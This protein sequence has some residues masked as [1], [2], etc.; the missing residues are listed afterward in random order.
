MCATAIEPL[1]YV[2][3]VKR[4]IDFEALAVLPLPGEKCEQWSSYDRASRYDPETEKYIAWYANA[5][6]DGFIRM[7]GDNFVIAEMEGPG[8]IWRIWSAQPEDGHVKIYLDG[9]TEP[10]VDL[11]F[12]DYFDLKHPP[13]IYPS[14]I[15]D[16]A[17]GKNCY[18]PIPYARSCKIIAEKGWGAFYHFTYSTFP[19]GT[20]VPTFQPDL[21]PQEKEALEKVDRFLSK[22]LGSDQMRIRK[23]EVT[24]TKTI[25]IPKDGTVTVA[26]LKGKGAL[27]AL[28]VRM[29]FPTPEEACAALGEIVLRIYWDGE[30]TPAVWVPLGDFF[31][32]APGPNKY[33][34]LP[35]GITED[36]FYSYWYMP[37]VKGALIEV[38]NEGPGERSLEFSITHASLTRPGESLGRFHAKWHRDAFLPAEPERGLDWPMLKTQ[39]RGRYCGVMLHVWN[40]EGDWWGEGDEKFFIDGEKFPSTFGTGSEDYFGY[41][42][43]NPALFQH[44]FHCQ[45]FNIGDNREISVNRWQIADNVPFQ[46]SFEGAIEK[47]F[48]ND[49]PT[50]YACTAYWYLAPGGID[51]YEPAAKGY[52]E[53]VLQENVPAKDYQVVGNCL[54]L[55]ISRQANMGFT[56]ESAD[57]G[58]G[59]LFDE[60]RSLINM[61]VGK[62]RFSGVPFEIIDPAKNNNRSCIILKGQAKPYFPEKAEGVAAGKKVK[63]IYVLNAAAYCGIE[64]IGQVSYV[65]KLNYADGT[66]GQIEARVGK[67]I[68]DWFSWC[69]V[70][71]DIKLAWQGKAREKSE[72]SEREF[73]IGI[74]CARFV[75]P[76]PD[77]TVQTI[78]IISANKSVPGIF[79]ITVEY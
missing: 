34:S 75:G 55:D 76:E 1:T 49:R 16:A 19:K 45:T 78:D 20:V 53:R 15:Y 56:D 47:Y 73:K 46:T 23:K 41:G 26:R 72:R 32:T 29:N 12:S 14:L 62:Q 54:T 5:D 70:G 42:W 60:G 66:S 9:A 58:K 17:S 65:L 57:D 10:A 28:K 79:A 77:K 59:G 4:L 31:G 18:V 13:F 44:A 51:P 30:Q 35:M 40:P 7:E 50:L 64:T 24:E 52:R 37:F 71:L 33:K 43:A 3:L 25:A 6:G 68:K 22:N 36:G 11:P 48:L 69:F 27:T 63:Y 39:G 38:I 8:C 61:P 74:G 21:S 2:D 67:A